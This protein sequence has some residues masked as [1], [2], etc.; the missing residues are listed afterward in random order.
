MK[1]ALDTNV[2]VYAEGLNGAPKA[3]VARQLLA[4]LLP[5]ACLPV[6]VA[7]EF[8]NVLTLKAGVA[9]GEAA[10]IVE[11]L[12]SLTHPLPTTDAVLTDALALSSR[13]GLRIFDC[14]IL[15]A[16]AAEGCAILLSEDMQDGFVH[17][18]VTVTDPFAERLHPLL[19]SLLDT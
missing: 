13:S 2:L 3:D 16:A 19:A 8:Y 7:A 11:D 14:L 15:A 5:D 18:G 4:R 10:A 9:R 6:Q 12:V 17:R 1:V